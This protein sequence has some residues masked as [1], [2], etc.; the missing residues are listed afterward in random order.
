METSVTG[1]TTPLLRIRAP[2]WNPFRFTELGRGGEAVVYHI[3]PD[4]AAKIFHAPGAPEFAGNPALQAAARVRLYDMQTKLDAFARDLPSGIVAPTGALVDAMERIFGYTMPF[5]Q[6]VPL[7]Q[8]TRTSSIGTLG[9]ILSILEQLHDLVSAV[10]RADA[11][12]GDLTEQNVMVASGVPHLVDADAM[13]F[14]AYP[15]RTFTP[16]FVAPELIRAIPQSHA[17]PAG[18]PTFEMVAPHTTLTDWYSFL[19][20]AMRLLTFTDPYGGI[21][22]G[23]DLAS[24]IEARATV[25]DRRVRYPVCARPLTDLPRPILEAFFRAFHNG[26]RFIPNRALF[27]AATLRRSKQ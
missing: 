21:V 5:V 24:R 20:L 16:R 12:V 11:V 9:I 6:G 14:G 15:C 25:F 19:V 10:H 23:M 27:T 18:L 7:D 8:L 3:K 22:D 13:Q 26:E 1:S 4:T 2:N 17:A